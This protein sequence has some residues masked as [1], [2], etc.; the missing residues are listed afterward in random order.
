M[1]KAFERRDLRALLVFCGGV[2]LLYAFFASGAYIG[3]R[4]R[5]AAPRAEEAA[6]QPADGADRG[7][8]ARFR[9]EVAVVDNRESADEIVSKLRRQYASAW[10]ALEPHDRLYHVYLG[11]YPLD[12]ANTVRAELEEQGL[13]SVAVKPN[14]R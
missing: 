5:P 1:A 2:L 4:S 13:Q 14:A 7:A 8:T 3:S 10:V 11:P 6:P 9:V 12:Q